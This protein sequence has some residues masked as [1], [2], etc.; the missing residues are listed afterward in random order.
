[1]AAMKKR[2]NRPASQADLFER[3]AY[4]EIASRGNKSLFERV[5]RVRRPPGLVINLGKVQVK[6]CMITFHADRFPA[7]RFAVRKPPLLHCR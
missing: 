2:Q 6:L 7:Q 3:A 1:M 5:N 4:P